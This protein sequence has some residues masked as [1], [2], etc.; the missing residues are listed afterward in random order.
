M[1]KFYRAISLSIALMV[2]VGCASSRGI[3]DI[4]DSAVVNPSQGLELKFIRVTDKREFQLKPKQASIPSLKNGEIHDPEITSRAIARKRNSYGQALGD[5]LLPEGRTVVEV[6]ENHLSNG[7]RENGYRVLSPGESNYENA[8][9]LEVDINN[10]WGWFSP[11]FW[12]IGL[13]FQT[14]IVVSAPMKE[15]VNV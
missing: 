9:P 2:M 6:V 5:I 15:F 4:E 11:G 14:A 3:I 13:N 7:F 10:F 8:I 1:N 12:S